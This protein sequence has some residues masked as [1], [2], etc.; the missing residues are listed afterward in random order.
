MGGD[1]SVVGSREARQ[2]YSERG[3]YAKLLGDAIAALRRDDP[4]RFDS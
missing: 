3:L 4:R 1:D 2:D